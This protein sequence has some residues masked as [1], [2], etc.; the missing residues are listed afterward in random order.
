MA[1]GDAQ[2]VICAIGSRGFDARKFEE[3]DRK[4]M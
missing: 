4:V 1:I 3:V 2:A